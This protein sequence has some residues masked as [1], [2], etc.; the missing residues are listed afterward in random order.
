MDTSFLATVLDYIL[1]FVIVGGGFRCLWGLIG[2][3]AAIKDHNGLAGLRY[4]GHL[5]AACD[6]VEGYNSAPH[7]PCV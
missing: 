2:L 3:G 5:H 6:F 1:M 7:L 4:A